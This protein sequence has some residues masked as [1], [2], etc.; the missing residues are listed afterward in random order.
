MR[1][2]ATEFDPATGITEE[3]WFDEATGKVT[4]NRIQDVE[5]QLAFNRAA[6]ASHNGKPNYANE[7]GGAHHVARIPLIVIEQWKEKGFDWFQST[8]AERRKVL[9]DPANRHLL[10]RPGRL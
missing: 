2:T 8:D 10:V 9:N 1:L 6:Y 5:D 7:K 4:I 3:F